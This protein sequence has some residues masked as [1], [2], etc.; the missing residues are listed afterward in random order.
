MRVLWMREA[1]SLKKDLL[2]PA[3]GSDWSHEQASKYEI[4]F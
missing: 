2:A 1:T 3:S 4:V